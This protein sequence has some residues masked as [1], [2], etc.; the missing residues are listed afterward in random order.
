MC[1]NKM[2]GDYSKNQETL[3]EKEL[4]YLILVL[5]SNKSLLDVLKISYYT[6]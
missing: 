2:E 3:S 5:L 4:F 6:E 1:F